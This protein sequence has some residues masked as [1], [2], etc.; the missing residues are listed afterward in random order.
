MKTKYITF[1]KEYIINCLY[2]LLDKTDEV[3]YKEVK[4]TITR[5]IAKI[6]NN[7]FLN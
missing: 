5:L 1:N 3:Y 7:T 6:E 4:T 2:Y